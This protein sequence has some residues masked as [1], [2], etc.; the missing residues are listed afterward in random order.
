MIGSVVVAILVLRRKQNA[1]NMVKL[2]HHTV[3]TIPEDDPWARR[4]LGGGE[5]SQLHSE[6]TRNESDGRARYQLADETVIRSELVGYEPPE[7]PS[8]QRTQ[9]SD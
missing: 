8:D 2:E 7:L 3:Q 5:I 6:D 4:E 1:R 9:R